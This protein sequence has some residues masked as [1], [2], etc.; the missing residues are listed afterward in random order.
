[1]KMIAG[2]MVGGQMIGGALGASGGRSGD[3]IYEQAVHVLDRSGNNRAFVSYLRNNGFS[4]A[5]KRRVFDV[6]KE[7]PGDGDVSTQRLYAGTMTADLTLSEYCWSPEATWVQFQWS[8]DLNQKIQ[9]GEYPN[10]VI[11]IYYP[12][13]AYDRD[14]GTQY[15]GNFVAVPGEGDPTVGDLDPNGVAFEWDEYGHHDYLAGDGSHNW[16]DLG[17]YVG[18]KLLKENPS[19]SP[20]TRLVTVDYEHTY[21][22]YPFMG[23]LKSVSISA[24]G[25]S[26]SLGTNGRSWDGSWEESEENLQY[27]GTSC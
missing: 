14:V 11:G 7:R 18:L 8:F 13:D 25:L 16:P 4:V 12:Y 3:D 2:S 15:G 24:A 26:I 9:S 6:Y 22:I 1:M 20:A 19:D 5:A 27:K 10:D 23:D 21:R 17:S